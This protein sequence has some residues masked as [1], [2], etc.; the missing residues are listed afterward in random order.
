MYVG[1][2]CE[3]KL[4][5]TAAR[6]YWQPLAYDPPGM[7]ASLWRYMEFAKFVALLKEGGL[8]FARADRLGDKFE[9]AKGVT[10]RKTVWDDHYR[11][12]FVEAIRNPPPG[13]ACTLSNEE[14]QSRADGLLKQLADSGVQDLRTTFVSCWHESE[15][16]S[17]ALWRLYC[18][19][20]SAGVAIRTTFESLRLSLG[21]D[22]SIAIG[23]V[24]YVDFRR[25]FAGV[26]EAIFR[27][28]QSLSHEK[29]VRAVIRDN[30]DSVAIG[31]ARPADLNLL[32][33]NVV[34][35]PFEGHW[36]EAVLR[37]TMARF[38]VTGEITPSEIALEPFY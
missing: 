12:F 35:S 6:F 28:R 18:P 33:K 8:Y 25:E 27:K 2:C 21:D 3:P 20:P 38:G 26:N 24:R 1:D 32:L 5:E 23:R 31:L 10:S 9:G 16:E 34:V 19:P 29:E 36:F 37:E 17:E 30:Q 14:I 13:E 15:V 22:P 4:A 11:R 7:G